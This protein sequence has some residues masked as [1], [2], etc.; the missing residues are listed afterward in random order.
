MNR[1]AAIANR[2][3]KEKCIVAD[4]GSDH[5]FLALIL[6][7]NK[8][9]GKIYNIE[10]NEKPLNVSINN[11]KEYIKTKNQ[12]YNSYVLQL[13]FFNFSQFNKRL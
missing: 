6:L 1:I 13:I 8:K 5:A 7:K 4:I 9:V 2:I 3:K 12:Q 11:T 10:I